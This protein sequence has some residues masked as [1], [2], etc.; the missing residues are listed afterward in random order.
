MSYCSELGTLRNRQCIICSA[1]SDP[2]VISAAHSAVAKV[3]QMRESAKPEMRSPRFLSR[4]T[5]SIS[6]M[7]GMYL[8]ILIRRRIRRSRRIL[9]YLSTAGEIRA[10]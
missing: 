8:S 1:S 10:M 6:V 7:L 9:S 2:I 4:K 3:A 5:S